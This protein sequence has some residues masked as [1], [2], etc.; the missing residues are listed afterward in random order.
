[1]HVHP[2][3]VTPPPSEDPTA[4]AELAALIERVTEDGRLSRQEWAE[5]RAKVQ[6]DGR[7]TPQE[8]DLL[9]QLLDR[10]NQGVIILED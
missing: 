1:M 9:N 10:V 5:I 2:G 8:V 6:E 7:V 4:L 3:N